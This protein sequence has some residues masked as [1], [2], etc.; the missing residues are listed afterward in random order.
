MTGST[1]L[2]TGKVWGQ[3]CS[4]LQRQKLHSGRLE[5]TAGHSQNVP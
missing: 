2:A 5:L 3:K 4:F 1:G